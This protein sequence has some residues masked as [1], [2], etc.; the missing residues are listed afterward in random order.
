LAQGSIIAQFVLVAVKF[1]IY[2][3]FISGRDLLLQSASGESRRLIV[4]LVTACGH[5]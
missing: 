5:G 2:T 3:S 1:V 4:A